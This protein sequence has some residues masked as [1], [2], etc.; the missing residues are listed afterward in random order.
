MKP[1]VIIKDN[2]VVITYNN[3]FAII[4]RRIRDNGLQGITFSMPITPKTA[5]LLD[6]SGIVEVESFS[7]S[8]VLTF[9]R[10]DFFETHLLIEVVMDI[11]M[12]H[13]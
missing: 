9:R 3:E 13:R 8:G 6:K 2:I 11:L 1:E 4:E 5:D 7:E 10:K 12:N